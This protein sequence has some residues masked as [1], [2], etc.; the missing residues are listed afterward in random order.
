MRFK[1]VLPT[2]LLGTILAGCSTFQPDYYDCKSSVT[3]YAEGARSSLLSEVTNQNVEVRFNGVSA[4]CY[5]SGDKVNVELGIGLKVLRDIAAGGDVAP[6]TVPLVAAIVDNTDNVTDTQGFV[7]NMQFIQN[8]D[9]IYPLV[10]RDM[11]MPIG[12]RIILSLTPEVISQ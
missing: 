5:D 7:Y 6:V 3:S 12:G 11:T 2:M 1:T 10:R 8:V 9:V 4:R